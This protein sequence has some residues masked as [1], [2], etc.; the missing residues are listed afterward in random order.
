MRIGIT[1]VLLITASLAIAVDAAEEHVFSG[2]FN[3]YEVIREMLIDNSTEGVAA[4]AEAIAAAAGSLADDFKA[5]SAG[6]AP[7]D[8]SAVQ[9]LLPEIRTRAEQLAAADGLAQTR[10]A[11]ASLTQPLVRWHKLVRGPR[12]VVAYCYTGHTGSLSTVAL[13]ILGYEV[14]NLLY[15]MNG[16]S[17]TRTA[18]I[19]GIQRTYLSRLI[20]ELQI[21]KS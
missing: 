13:G 17:Q 7:E 18:K 6:V 20:K 11:L 15:G 3:H 21:N 1:S 19:L 2:L 16:W 8:A 14:T 9:A 4:H 12:P 10:A 5:E